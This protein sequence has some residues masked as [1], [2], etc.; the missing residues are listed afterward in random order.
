MFPKEGAARNFDR[1][2]F[3]P[4]IESTPELAEILPD[5]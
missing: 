2:K 4:M 3:G 1:E 5:A